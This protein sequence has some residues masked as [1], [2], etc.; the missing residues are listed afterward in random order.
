MLAVSD[1]VESFHLKVETNIQT[2]FY[3]EGVLLQILDKFGNVKFVGS[4]IVSTFHF[5][6]IINS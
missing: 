6:L 3:P 5:C 1:G 4:P 2:G